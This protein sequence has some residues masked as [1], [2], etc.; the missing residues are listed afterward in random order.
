MAENLQG[1]S[2]DELSDDTMQKL[3]EAM[4]TYMAVL[5]PLIKGISELAEGFRDNDVVVAGEKN[6]LARTDIDN[7]QIAN[8]LEHKNEAVKL[9]DD[10]FSDLQVM[11]GENGDFVI[12]NSS[13][14]VSK[15]KKGGKTAG[16]LGVIGPMRINY[17]KIIPYIEYLTDRI[18]EM[19]S[20]DEPVIAEDDLKG[21]PDMQSEEPERYERRKADDG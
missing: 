14:I 15:I 3:Y 10:S 1:V 13:V 7:T 8:F 12:E 18:T 4:G 5:A 21:L 17:A 19:I 20:D 6:L 16:S 9:L 2:S 11:F